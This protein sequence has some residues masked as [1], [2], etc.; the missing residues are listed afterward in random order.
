MPFQTPINA[1]LT[2]AQNGALAKLSSV[3]TYLRAPENPFQNLSKD[4]QISSFDFSIKSLDS[5]VGNNVSEIVL[6][7]FLTKILAQ[8]G[9]DSNLLEEMIVSS[10]A[11][12]FDARGKQISQNQSN[13]EWLTQNVL[14]SLT[15]GKRLLAKQIITMIFGPKDKMSDDPAQQDFLLNASACEEKLF[16]VTNNPSVSEKELEF[17]RVKL[18]KQLEKG[19]VEI[20]VN[21]Q[22][23][24]IRLPDDFEEQFNLQ[25]SQAA[26]IPESQRPNPATSFVLLQQFVQNESSSQRNEEDSRAVRKNFLQIII[27]KLLSLISVSLSLDPSFNQAFSS[28]NQELRNSNQGEESASSICSDPCE[29]SD[30]CDSGNKQRFKELSSFSSGLINSLYALV[31]SMLLRKLINEAKSMVKELI[32]AKAKEKIQRLIEKQRSKFKFLDDAQNAT[33][34]ASQYQEN[35]KNIKGIFDYLK[36]NG[37]NAESSA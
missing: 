26:G 14:P 5:L 6:Q 11:K 30:A 8:T 33:S 31:V 36:D 37:T 7:Q 2:E 23:L 25:D 1:S 17:N 12:S 22:K 4:Q 27:D 3:Q 35:L 29:I 24:E 34:K 13:S 32:V 18:K 21:C 19:A 28:I 20:I 10:L 9:P 16:S 15:I